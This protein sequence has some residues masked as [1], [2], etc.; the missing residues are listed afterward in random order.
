MTAAP[1]WNHMP[2]WESHG[3]WRAAPNLLHTH[4]T[5]NHCSFTA[6]PPYFSS[7]LHPA[8]SHT[9]S[10]RGSYC[11]RATST[12]S[13]KHTWQLWIEHQNVFFPVSSE[14]LGAWRREIVALG[15]EGAHPD[16]YTVAEYTSHWQSASYCSNSYKQN[17]MRKTQTPPCPAG[18]LPSF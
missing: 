2:G 11:I 17:H 14:D 1:L 9:T 7:R 13:W 10:Q 6:L 15:G 4:S 12:H 8:G 18:I 3:F 5:P 16:M